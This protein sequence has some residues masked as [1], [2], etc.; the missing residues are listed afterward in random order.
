MK[1]AINRLLSIVLCVCVLMSFTQIAGAN[2]NTS[3][4]VLSYT[5][6]PLVYRVSQYCF[7]INEGL[8]R[9]IK[10]LD[11]S[12][13]N[14]YNIYVSLM[15]QI[16]SPNKPLRDLF[17]LAG[18]RES[19]ADK[20]FISNSLRIGM[21]EDLV[22]R[23]ALGLE[24]LLFN[25]ELIDRVIGMNVGVEKY[26]DAL[27]SFMQTAKA[28]LETLSMI[29]DA[30]SILKNLSKIVDNPT[31]REIIHNVML[32]IYEAKS[33][34]DVKYALK[35]LELEEYISED[36]TIDFKC[37]SISK[38]LGLAGDALSLGA[39][40]IDGICNLIS[41]SSN[42]ELY[43]YYSDFLEVLRNDTSLPTIMRQA[44]NDLNTDIKEQYKLAVKNIGQEFAGFATGKLLSI[45]AKGLASVGVEALG[46]ILVAVS[47]GKLIGNVLFGVKDQVK[48]CAAIECYD[49]IASRYAEIVLDDKDTFLN[50]PTHENAERFRFDYEILQK[51]RL[52]G[53]ERY[54]SM[55]SY[56]DLWIPLTKPMM[57]ALCNY[58]ENATPLKDNIK[59]IKSAEFTYDEAAIMEELKNRGFYDTTVS[60]ECPVDVKV[61][62][63]NNTLVAS[64]TNEVLEDISSDKSEYPIVVY[65]EGDNKIIRIVSSNGY[66]I[67]VDAYDSGKMTYTSTKYKASNELVS[68]TVY[69]DIP[70]DKGDSFVSNPNIDEDLSCRDLYETNDSETVAIEPTKEYDNKQLPEEK[71]DVADVVI[72]ETLFE[73]FSD[74]VI[75][76][77]S[78]AMMSMS[79][80]VDVSAYNL[81]VEDAVALFSAISKKYPVEYSLLTKSDF[82][83]R[84]V[85]SPSRGTMTTIRFYYDEELSLSNY[86]K[87]ANETNA[88]IEALVEKTKGMTDFEKALYIHDYIVLNCEYDLD[89]L[90][91]MEQSGGKL[92]GEIYN[93]RYTEYSV[94]VNGTGICGSYALAYRAVMNACGLECLYLS[95]REM[96]HGWNMVKIDGKW[97]HV[98]CC[99][100]DPVPDQYGR[101]G[102]TY[103]L[104]TDDEFM[105]LN[106]YSWT[107]ENYKATSTKYSFMPRNPDNKQKYDDG[108]WYYISSG[109]L[110]KCDTYGNNCE[111]LANVTA[112][113]L[114]VEN[115]EVYYSYGRGIYDLDE[116]NGNS[117]LSYY[118]P[119]NICGSEMNQ[120][121]LKNLYVDGDDATFF[122]AV[123]DNGEYKIV[124]NNATDAIGKYEGIK[125]DFSEITL[126]FHESKQLTC[127]LVQGT[128]K[129]T[130][131]DVWWTSSDEEVADVSSSGL[132]TGYKN[133]TAEINATWN[134]VSDTCAVE[135][136]F[137]EFEF[138]NAKHLEYMISNGEATIIGYDGSASGELIIP[139]TISG[140][141]VT[142]IGDSAFYRCNSLT[143]ITIPDSVTSIG[144]DAFGGCY[145]LTSVTIGNGVTSIG[146]GAFYFCENLTSV[147]IGNGVTSIGED[148]FYYCENLTS[149]RIG[150]SVTSIGDYAFYGCVSLTSITIPDSVTSIGD[151]AFDECVSLTSIT[152]PDSVTSIGEY[153]FGLCYSITVDSEN[154]YYSSDEN[155]ILYNKNKTELIQYPIGNER[156]EFT[157][158]KGVTSIGDYAFYFCDSLTSVTIPDSVTSIGYHAF[159][160]CDSL[161]SITIPDSVT[162]IGEYAFG[163]CESLTSVTIGNGVTSIGE[164]A[165]GLCESLTSV[166]IGNSVT[167]IGYRAFYRCDSLTSVT[168]PDS[169][170][171]IGD[172][173]FCRCNSLTSITIPDSV[174]SIGED[175]FYYCNSLTDVYYTGAKVDWNKISIG[176]YNEDLTNATIHFHDH[177]YNCETTKVV[178]CTEDGI[179]TYTCTCGDTYTE[180]ITA[181]G[182]SY[183]MVSR[184]AGDCTKQ[185]V[186]VY[187]C[188]NCKD[189]YEI[190]DKY[191]GHSYVLDVHI[192]TCLLYGYTQAVCSVCNESVMFD[193]VVPTGHSMQIDRK[194]ATCTEHATVS[195]LCTICGYHDEVIDNDSYFGEHL[196]TTHIVASTCK[197]K[198]YTAHVC[199]VCG[200]EFFDN[201]T[202]LSDHT[203]GE[204]TVTVPPTTEN[205]GV[206]AL[207]CSVCGETL[208]TESVPKLEIT[209][210]VNSVL[211]QDVEV[212]YKRSVALSPVIDATEDAEYTVSYSSSDDTVAKIDSNGNVSGIKRGEATITCTVTDLYGNSV[213][214]TC[215]VTV[216][217]SWW[218]WIIVIVLFG[219]IWY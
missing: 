81:K 156:T 131:S 107:P 103:F 91:I 142:S 109:K 196:Y 36:A 172:Y 13:P 100:D 68:E 163:W 6:D 58:K 152:I 10:S 219:W 121:Y 73:G 119:D 128:D 178:T 209:E 216:K 117:T 66:R 160:C 16:E 154:K 20:G 190:K 84:I 32:S 15:N 191:E 115:G 51:L 211:V 210:K 5:D 170:T 141:P 82:S 168:I 23:T 143:S 192:P 173:A 149:V 110:Y 125:L 80:S 101:A 179:K 155:G 215:K 90:E 27:K 48:S 214:D 205:E 166:T 204:W 19:N 77:V 93:E 35:A 49:I 137:D 151:Y 111:V 158:P 96:N 130:V 31:G 184:V 218:Q 95:S 59:Q 24:G 185:G 136:S 201:Y 44:A 52:A 148:A 113:T 79:S 153:A 164:Y 132:V 28:D 39:I 106:H 180:T 145:S 43:E 139:S 14:D 123:A 53:E 193:F 127:K 72:A 45:G 87:R 208:Q 194:D 94:L 11:L 189:S 176:L 65:T 9:Y 105:E 104:R 146:D 18:S 78:Q 97:Y 41:V 85:F 198:G 64:V 76:T 114:D 40:T 207:Y 25:G 83:Y 4:A 213:T 140:Y 197:D 38:A 99:W 17:Y 187:E 89:L 46:N 126:S 116:E 202:E 165:F 177:S 212:M 86:Q 55:I 182:H 171:S 161:T 74:E 108:Y 150:N 92:S 203:P 175:A 33:A 112:N 7:E 147:R 188:A 60:V 56:D 167:S 30:T 2:I 69:K 135:V 174:T 129:C 62:D 133:G 21:S 47:I 37:G 120:A 144:E 199:S 181:T 22:L 3:A 67:E 134:N 88:A 12:N 169:V 50:N 159:F 54:L 124:K 102:R 186:S 200:D 98:D 157:I 75:E 8:V 71:A 63:K 138:G 195:Y 162:S 61:Y 34:D 118:L 1:K 29:K 42:L 70:L 183:S 217:Y 122:T 206:K 57:R 26:K